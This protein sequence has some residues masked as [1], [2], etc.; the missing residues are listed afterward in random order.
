LDGARSNIEDCFIWR[1]IVVDDI[2]LRPNTKVQI[3]KVDKA[4]IDLWIYEEIQEIYMGP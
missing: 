1:T 2:R 3:A 4:A